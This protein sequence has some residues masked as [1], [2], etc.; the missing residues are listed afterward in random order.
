MAIHRSTVSKRPSVCLRSLIRLFLC[1]TASVITQQI[2][3]DLNKSKRRSF[4]NVRLLTGITEYSAGD[5]FER[6]FF[7][8]LSPPD[9]WENHRSHR[10]SAVW[11][12]QGN[13]F[14]EWKM[15]ETKSS[16]LWVHGKRPLIPNT[17]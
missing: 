7:K 14:S 6:E 2:A 11:F 13:T 3:N 9:P 17:Q 16:L 15:S 10:E 1:L 5:K 8:W 12:I 4:F